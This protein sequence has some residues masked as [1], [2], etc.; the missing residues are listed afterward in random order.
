MSLTIIK[1]KTVTPAML[2]STT[3]N[4]STAPEWDA[5]TTYAADVR[6]TLAST[7]RAYQSL[8]AAN[9]NHDPVTAVA[10]WVDVGPC[11]RWAMFDGALGSATED[12]S[13]ITVVIRPGQVSA[14]ALLQ[15]QAE[16]VRLRMLDSP[17][18]AVV[19]ERTEDMNRLFVGGWYEWTTAPFVY[20]PEAIFAGLPMYADCEL[21]VTL[22]ADSLNPVKCGEM[23][24]GSTYELGEPQHGAK[25]GIAD[26]STK[27]TDAWGN[28]TLLERAFA[29]TLD[30]PMRLDAKQ[31]TRVYGVLASLRATPCVVVPSTLTRYASLV[32]YGWIGE[33]SI[34]LTTYSHHYCTLQIKGLT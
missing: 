18:G 13:E 7:R 1:P 3:A 31:L 33:F 25:F 2:A 8:Q 22:L 27:E 21:Q 23:I 10:W 34:D 32:V 15:V 9:T 19:F 28:T 12:A 20:R 6:V 14:V 24:V 17:G 11:N 29:K 16:S 26:Y 5:G 30:M 4:E